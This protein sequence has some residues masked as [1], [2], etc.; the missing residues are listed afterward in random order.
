MK[1]AV[2][3]SGSSGNCIYIEMAGRHILVDAGISNRAIGKQLG[4]LDIDK[5]QIDSVLLTHEH[6]DHIRGVDVFARYQPHVKV[7]AN[8]LTWRAGNKFLHRVINHQRQHIRTQA[9]FAIGRVQVTPFA[10]SHDAADPVGYKFEAEGQCM[11][12]ATDLGTISDDVY[13]HLLNADALVIESNHD[14]HM[15]QK[16]PYPYFLKQRIAGNKGHLPNDITADI[17]TK[18]ICRRTQAVVLAHLS[19][20]NNTPEIAIRASEQ[21]LC[22][23]GLRPYKDFILKTANRSYA[24]PL[25]EL[26]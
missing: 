8:P 21:T 22:A 12:V 18:V 17:L 23:A 14:R 11:V 19:D 13:Q 3:A 15:L 2:L 9:S 6:V 16:G 5:R 4:S 26:I 7:Y 20:K 1:F 24:T 10:V 25:I